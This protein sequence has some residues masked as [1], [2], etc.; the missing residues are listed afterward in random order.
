MFSFPAQKLLAVLLTSKFSHLQAGAGFH[1]LGRVAGISLG[2][3]QY[4]SISGSV[5]LEKLRGSPHHAFHSYSILSVQDHA[6]QKGIWIFTDQHSEKR[7]K[8]F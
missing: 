7:H 2:K 6:P 5:F 3:F 8:S 1:E 4:F